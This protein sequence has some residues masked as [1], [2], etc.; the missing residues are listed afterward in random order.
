MH[1]IM[2]RL[3]Y[4]SSASHF[5]RMKVLSNEIEADDSL[6]KME[7]DKFE[8]PEIKFSAMNCDDAE[9]GTLVTSLSSVEWAKHVIIVELETYFMFG[10]MLNSSDAVTNILRLIFNNKAIADCEF[11]R[12]KQSPDN[13]YDWD[14]SR[15]I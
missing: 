12:I 7:L 9:G 1:D 14:G 8:F 10:L 4:S 11:Y 15:I 3:S 13:T 6:I 2:A 5:S